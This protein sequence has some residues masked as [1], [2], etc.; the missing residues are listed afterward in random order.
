MPTLEAPLPRGCSFIPPEGHKALIGRVLKPSD[1]FTED[2]W[3]K[4][5]KDREDTVRGFMESATNYV[6]TGGLE[7]QIPQLNDV[8][9]ETDS[10]LTY[11]TLLAQGLKDIREGKLVVTTNNRLGITGGSNKT[12]AALAIGGRMNCGVRNGRESM[13]FRQMNARFIGVVLNVDLP[14]AKPINESSVIPGYRIEN[15]YRAIISARQ[16]YHTEEQSGNLGEYFTQD[17][18]DRGLNWVLFGKL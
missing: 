2:R 14:E 6:L 15:I 13:G 1:R 17:E 5:W 16:D 4:Q 3:N 7:S 10:G 8:D 18:L 11:R 9:E 12:N